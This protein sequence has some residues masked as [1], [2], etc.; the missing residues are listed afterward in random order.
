[1]HVL[2]DK[3]YKSIAHAQKV[4]AKLVNRRRMDKNKVRSGDKI[5][6]SSASF[7]DPVLQK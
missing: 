1:M 7:L 5:P 6:I 2:P 3:L 4:L